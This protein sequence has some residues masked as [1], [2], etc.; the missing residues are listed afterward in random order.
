MKQR[1]VYLWHLGSRVE[2]RANSLTRGGSTHVSFEGHEAPR[3][4]RPRRRDHVWYGKS[5]VFSLLSDV[6]YNSTTVYT[7]FD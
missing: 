5:D 7:S 1:L 6:S 3:R 2:D 4:A